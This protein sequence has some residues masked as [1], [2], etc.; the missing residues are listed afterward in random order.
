[1][2]KKIH[3]CVK[4]VNFWPNLHETS[5]CHG[6][7]KN[8]GHTIDIS[9]LLQ[10]MNEQPLKVS[11]ARSKSSFQNFKKNL[12]VGM[13]SVPLSPLHVPGSWDIAKILK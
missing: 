8:D 6:N 13:A 3:K 1:M 9:K 7:A 12:I 11:P 2:K 4:K 10:R 5:G